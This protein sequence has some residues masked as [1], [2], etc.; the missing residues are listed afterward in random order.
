[1]G[2]SAWMPIPHN[3]RCWV[4]GSTPARLIHRMIGRWPGNDGVQT[5]CGNSVCLHREG[6]VADY[7]GEHGGRSYPSLEDVPGRFR[8]CLKCIALDETVE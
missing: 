6:C 8:V 5:A 2:V 1:M 4:V 3:E 7:W